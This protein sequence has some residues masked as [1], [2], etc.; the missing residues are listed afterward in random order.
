MIQYR[1]S[2]EPP[3]LTIQLSGTVTEDDVHDEFQ[4]FEKILSTL[5][6]RYVVLV[7]CLEPTYL[8][9]PAVGPLYYYAVRALDTDPGLTVLLYGD[10]NPDPHLSAFLRRVV[11]GNRVRIA[12]S[13]E[14]A[15]RL[16]AR[17]RNG[18]LSQD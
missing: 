14:E 9:P 13:E 3:H 15:Q 18:T 16:F 10:R 12:Q 11:P 7:D 6:S 4:E 5:P 17:Y 2:S 1:T 8:T